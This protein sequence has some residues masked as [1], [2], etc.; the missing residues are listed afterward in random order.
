MDASPE[1][2]ATEILETVPLL[3]R[4][5]RMNVRSQTTPELSIPQFRAL[6]FLGRNAEAMLT[7]VAAFLGLTL[8][9]TSKLIDGLV[10]AGMATRETHP[11]NRRRVVLAL[12]RLGRRKYDVAV[13]CA[14]SFLAD[15]LES[16]GRAE[17]ARVYDSMKVLHALFSD[18]NLGDRPQ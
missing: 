17:R 9:S 2:C 7:D 11:T 1:N 4:I 8:P 3:M 15:R 10:N 18:T 16:L 14:R 6:A 5:I 13:T 12:T